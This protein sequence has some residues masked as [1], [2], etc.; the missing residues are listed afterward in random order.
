MC[1]FFRVAPVTAAAPQGCRQ[2]DRCSF[3]HDWTHANSVRRHLRETW[4]KR[5]H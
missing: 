5:T 3:L 4:T 1:R 2:G